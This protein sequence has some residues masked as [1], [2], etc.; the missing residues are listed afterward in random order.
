[1]DVKQMQ[2]AHEAPAVTQSQAAAVQ[3]GGFQTNSRWV[4]VI[5]VLIALAALM[6]L[7][8]VYYMHVQQGHLNRDA[9]DIGQIARNVFTGHGYTTNLIRP[10][11]AG[12]SQ[13]GQ[14]AFPEINRA[15]AISLYR[16]RGCSDLVAYPGR[17]WV[18]LRWCFSWQCWQRHSGWAFALQL[19]GRTA[20]GRPC[21][22]KQAYVGC[23]HIGRGMDDAGLLF[24]LLLCVVALH[25]KASLQKSKFSGIGYSVAAGVFAA[26]LYCTHYAMF[27]LVIPL[28]VYF[29]ITGKARTASLVA[30]LI[31]A[32]GL[33][34]PLVVR[35]YSL[36]SSPI[37]GA[38][39]WDVMADT[40]AYPGDV[41]YRSV[42]SEQCSMRSLLMFPLETFSII[43]GEGLTE[44][45]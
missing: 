26:L 16:R 20:R 7:S 43:L 31:V 35:N 40:T 6:A 3:P 1:M 39:A 42:R 12:F 23:R 18:Q 38:G 32:L 34:A 10:F 30:F 4:T 22:V 45:C 24:T 36:T 15:A 11:N 5:L 13:S 8:V 2:S 25:H 33:M 14:G 41:F 27:L 44:I 37:M 9:C 21:G 28:A 29:A 17:R 19:P